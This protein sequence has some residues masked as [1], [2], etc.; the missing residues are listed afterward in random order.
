MAYV[1]DC[2]RLL[3]LLLLLFLSACSQKVTISVMDPMHERQNPAFL[4]DTIFSKDPEH[5]HNLIMHNYRSDTRTGFEN[6]IGHTNYFNQEWSSHRNNIYANY[7]AAWSAL[8]LIDESIIP[9]IGGF[10]SYD[11]YITNFYMAQWYAKRVLARAGSGNDKAFKAGRELISLT[12]HGRSNPQ[13]FYHF[14]QA[15]HAMDIKAINTQEVR[16]FETALEQFLD[17]QQRHPRWLPLVVQD[18]ISILEQRLK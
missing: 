3:I 15:R 18:H 5:C 2:C 10:N 14:L 8:Y 13:V 4:S 17:L 7:F 1:S 16:F 12:E 11:R 9:A 6:A